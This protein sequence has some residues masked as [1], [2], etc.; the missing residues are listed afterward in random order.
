MLF[1]Y[2]LNDYKRKLLINQY[3][4]S[5]ADEKK[6]QQMLENDENVPIDKN[7]YK[8]LSMASFKNFSNNGEMSTFYSTKN[9]QNSFSLKKI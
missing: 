6:K 4:Y 9:G 2:M 3:S 1:K 8:T 5:E 7:M